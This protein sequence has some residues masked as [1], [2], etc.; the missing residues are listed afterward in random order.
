MSW[1]P[2]PWAVWMG[3]ASWDGRKLGWGL[4]RR[5]QCCHCPSHVYRQRK[6]SV[7]S[8]EAAFRLVVSALQRVRRQESFMFPTLQ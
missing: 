2:E 1:T 4:L 8:Q 3:A 7:H 6:D 5:K